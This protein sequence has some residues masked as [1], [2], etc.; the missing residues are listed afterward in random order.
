MP[1]K[2]VSFATIPSLVT[3]LLITNQANSHT[4]EVE[5]YTRQNL[6]HFGRHVAKAK[7]F[8]QTSFVP[9]IRTGMFILG[10]S[11]QL[12]RSPLKKSRSR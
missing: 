7:L 9:V 6:C 5:I 8:C 1:C 2:V 11:A 10:C 4:F 3:L 12:P